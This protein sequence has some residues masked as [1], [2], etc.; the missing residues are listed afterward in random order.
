MAM[1]YHPGLLVP[2]KRLPK[3]FPVEQPG[4]AIHRHLLSRQNTQEVADLD[5]VIVSVNEVKNR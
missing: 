1:F 3:H 2:K 4:N 5:E